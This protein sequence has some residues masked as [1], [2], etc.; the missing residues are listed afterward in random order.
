M[1]AFTEIDECNIGTDCDE[2]AGCKNTNGSF[3][4]T[5]NNGFRGNGVNCV[6]TYVAKSF[7]LMLHIF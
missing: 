2:N 7:S 4:C 1:I 5:C 3:T 6:G